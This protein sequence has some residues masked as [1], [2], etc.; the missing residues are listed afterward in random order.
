V[1]SEAELEQKAA[2]GD[3]RAQFQL[4]KLLLGGPKAAREGA[5]GLS[6]IEQAA[7]KGH[8]DATA[9][10]ALFEAMGVNRT[11]D[12]GRALDRLQEAAEQGSSSAR[13]QLGL[14]ARESRQPRAKGQRTGSSWEALRSRVDLRALVTSGEHRSLSDRPLVRVIEGFASPAECRW[15]IERGREHL[16]PA[17]VF[18]PVTGRLAGSLARSNSSAE[19]Q[20][21]DMDLVLEVIRTRISA[22]VRLPLTHFEPTQVLHYSPGQEFRPHFDFLNPAN[23]ALREK[24]R[25]GQRV[26]TFL[27]Y[28]NEGFEGGETEFVDA[29]LRF[30]GRTGDALFWA[31]VDAQ[32]RPDPM[33]RHAG[34]PPTSGEKWILSQW[35][36]DRGGQVR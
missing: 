33:S 8:G 1:A 32:S 29:H 4:G 19:F 11:A 22:A 28:L 14:L 13:L 18:D 24:L 12:W 34:L 9:L 26:G 35:I 30:K 16:L 27:I 17:T 10:T 23:P 20:I 6:L 25:T 31:N 36:R 5:R 2:R 3:V 7:A 21:S 15:L